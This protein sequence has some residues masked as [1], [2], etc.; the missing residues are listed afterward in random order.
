MKPRH[1]DLGVAG[2]QRVE[3]RGANRHLVWRVPDGS[4]DHHLVHKKTCAGRTAAQS[5]QK[6]RRTSR[7]MAPST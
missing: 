7:A 3:S 4:T 5:S 1:W 2:E 6:T